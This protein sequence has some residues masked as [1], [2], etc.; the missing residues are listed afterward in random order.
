M[1]TKI[2]TA[3]YTCLLSA[4]S[5]HAD[6]LITSGNSISVLTVPTNQT[7]L[8]SSLTLGAFSG[9]T[10][11]ATPAYANVVQNGVTN[12]LWLAPWG[13][14]PYAITGACQI[15]FISSFPQTNPGPVVVSYKLIQS[16]AIHSFFAG[17]GLTN[18]IAVPAGKTIR[19]FDKTQIDDSVNSA[20]TLQQ[21]TNTLH[22]V[23]IFAGNE[24]TGPLTITYSVNGQFA[25]LVS[26]YFT[27]DFFAVPDS[28]YL[29]G[30]SG[31][32]E[33]TV[34]KSVDLTNWYPAVVYPTSTDQKAFYRLKILK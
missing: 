9:D 11:T 12:T 16:P 20:F 8:I 34:Q 22:D 33:I 21:G 28:G 10:D 3:A 1:K 7:L 5:A 14:G 26:Y 30:P 23:R 19:F 25:Q 17:S 24:F 31:S 18:T 4:L 2:V 13:G 29:Q 27:D 6:V 32:F 15:S